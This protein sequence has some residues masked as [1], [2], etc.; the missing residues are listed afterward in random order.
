MNATLLG[1]GYDNRL[2]YLKHLLKLDVI[3]VKS[4][5]K[6]ASWTVPDEW[7]VRDAWVKDPQGNKILDYK[8]NPMSLVVYSLPFS[9]K[10]S[11]EELQKHLYYSD[12]RPDDT[13]H[14]FKFYER[15][16]GFAIPK[17]S[18]K[19]KII[20]DN[21]G[22]LICEDGVCI[23]KTEIDPSVGKVQIEGVTDW[24]PEFKDS[25]ADGEYEVFIDTE[26][27]PGVMKIGVH[28]IKG[29]SDREILL[30][31]HLDH[32]FQANDN[33]SSVAAL[34]H[35]ST[36]IKAKSTIKIIFCPE[37]IGSIAYAHLADISKVDFAL[38]LE[39]CGNN[40]SLLLQKAFD[41]EARINRVAHCAMQILGE[42]YRK[43]MFRNVI[44][45][46]EYIFN[47][48]MIGIPSIL[49]T[50]Y[51]YKEYHT[52][53][54]TP[55]IINE[56]MIE[57]TVNAVLKIIEIWEADFVPVRNM[58]SP[59]MRSKY[60]IQSPSQQLNLNLDYVW[61]S[62]DG[63]KSLAEIA[64]EYEI[65]FDYLLETFN[66]LENDKA[67]SRA[68]AGKKPVKKAAPKKRKRV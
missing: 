60:G 31:A 56:E 46:D 3:E 63:K 65:A 30:F 28:T 52:D 41:N 53:K 29:E 17:N 39:C 67:I 34:C 2:E 18:I 23:P 50:R 13:P 8:L 7:I 27:K 68:D 15:D 44:G 58:A 22:D 14:V 4:G 19:E 51:P 42:S 38:A 21:A 59:L 32:P 61:Y 43:A 6:F 25:L 55:E 10:V 54:D 64:C 66:K 1:E 33:L 5:T 12:E 36:Q 16:W 62:V 26:F 9:G 24:K 48:P 37:T 49:L 47:D 11:R 35:L 45:S 57:K 40:H 20:Y